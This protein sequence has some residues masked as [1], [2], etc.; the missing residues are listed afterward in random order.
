MISIIIP[1]LEEEKVIGRTLSLLKSQLTI[2]HEIIVS[3]GGSKDK[4]VDIAE[5]LADKVVIHDKN[6]RQTIAQGRNDGAKV[7]QGNFF[8]FI[9]ADCIIPEPNLFFR[10][11][12]SSFE[13]K[14]RLVAL[15]ACFRFFPEAETFGDRVV[16]WSRDFAVRLQNNLFRKGDCAGGEFQMVRRDA[17][18]AVGGYRDDLVTLEDRDLFIR[19]AKIGRTMSDPDLVVF[20]SGR[21][22]HAVGWPRLIGMF[23]VNFI[24]F[25]LRGR[26]H[27][28]EWKPVR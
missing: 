3:D 21:R 1:T 27:S 11:A 25:Y 5:K 6:F 15:T 16:L 26:L 2:P 13:A 10:S 24:S 14:P 12:I 20:H 19:L 22:A 7:A 18:M 8:V 4:T 9:D 17:F 28:K 23:F